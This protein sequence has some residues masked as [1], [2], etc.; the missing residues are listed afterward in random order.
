MLRNVVYLYLFLCSSRLIQCITEVDRQQIVSNINGY[1]TIKTTDSKNK[2]Y[3]MT[4]TIK[5]SDKH[6]SPYSVVIHNDSKNEKHVDPTYALYTATSCKSALWI[7]QKI[8]DFID[9]ALMCDKDKPTFEKKLKTFTEHI[10]T[11]VERF[12]HILT[13]FLEITSNS[14]FYMDIGVLKSLISLNIKINLMSTRTDDDGSIYFTK[15]DKEI[16]ELLLVEIIELQRFV[17]VHCEYCIRYDKTK[18]WGLFNVWVFTDGEYGGDESVN[19]FLS[20]IASIGLESDN[21]L[22]NC[23]AR[24]ILI[25]NIIKIREDDHVSLM[26]SEVT[27]DKDQWDSETVSINEIVDQILI[28]YD[29][30]VIRWYHDLILIAIMKLLCHMI[31]EITKERFSSDVPIKTIN[32]INNK[33]P[34]NID[35]LPEYFIKGFDLLKRVDNSNY[36]KELSSYSDSLHGVHIKFAIDR[37]KAIVNLD[38]LLQ[39]ILDYI[40]HITCAQKYLKYLRREDDRYYTPGSHDK[41]TL[42]FSDSNVG[43]SK[44]FDDN[45]Q[46]AACRFVLE[47]YVFSIHANNFILF[48]GNK[49]MELVFN[50]ISS[51][52]RIVIR[53]E[54]YNWDLIKMAYNIAALI[55]NQRIQIDGKKKN[56]FLYER[57]LDILMAEL[58]VYRVKFCRNKKNDYLS[59]ENIDTKNQDT[60]A[61]QISMHDI[62]NG[63]YEIDYDVDVSKLDAYIDVVYNVDYLEI[64][65]LYEHFVKD[66][67]I[68]KLYKDVVK[69]Y[70]NIRLQ[71]INTVFTDLRKMVFNSQNVY[72]LYDI[73][74]K[75]YLAVIF[76]EVQRALA[77]DDYNSL[78]MELAKLKGEFDFSMCDDAF[79]N[80][81]SLFKTD[82]NAIFNFTDVQDESEA[83]NKLRLKI[84][85]AAEKFDKF[86]FVIAYNT[87][88]SWFKSFQISIMR[89]SL[90]TL[91]YKEINTSVRS[92]NSKFFKIKRL[93]V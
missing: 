63:R 1:V 37:E 33:I 45:V 66:G 60:E 64:G 36:N 85:E 91:L 6:T 40:D 14:S 41:K 71:S 78:T 30:D 7:V 62:F 81:L 42:L 17:S 72:A 4:V 34:K 15:S 77:G 88:R 58:N 65:D 90:N 27:L 51:Y 92:F 19:T 5:N 55:H 25:E 9:G 22:K 93:I 69:V 70:W 38:Q 24:N 49:N 20:V 11:N 3:H 43:E 73:Y 2:P 13:Y 35:D 79:P 61:L 47:L 68:I 23:S 86:N 52:C 53:H 8:N 32:D 29:I 59:F 48:V 84:T 16:V 57:V 80:D 67:R 31:I 28:S 12:T 89:N 10:R 83:V 82:L 75:F 39:R 56:F 44:N 18:I 87:K 46:T 76:Y 50:S 54:K 21:P 74:N 26:I